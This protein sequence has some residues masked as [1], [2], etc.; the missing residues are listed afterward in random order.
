MSREIVCEYVTV[1]DCAAA[2]CGKRTA[3]AIA[4][5][6]RSDKSLGEGR[7]INKW[8]VDFEYVRQGIFVKK[9]ALT[10]TSTVKLLRTLP[11]IG[12]KSLQK[13]IPQI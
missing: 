13:K 3:K 9:R 4:A 7:I 2:C 8:Q 5:K 12:C 10:N 6:N 1:P 11:L